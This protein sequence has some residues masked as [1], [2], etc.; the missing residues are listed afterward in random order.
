MAFS[1]LSL[2]ESL[3]ILAFIKRSRAMEKNASK[4]ITE[5]ERET[6]LAEKR[7][8]LRH[9]HLLDQICRVLSPAFFIV[10]FNYYVLFVAQGDDNDC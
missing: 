3:I 10:F 8:S 7:K 9:A 1:V 6:F 2:V 5:L 4:A